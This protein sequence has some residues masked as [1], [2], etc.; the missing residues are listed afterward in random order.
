M[1][2]AP[3][4]SVEELSRITRASTPRRLA[5][6]SAAMIGRDEKP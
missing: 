2:D 1:A 4:P 6:T 3:A 5:R